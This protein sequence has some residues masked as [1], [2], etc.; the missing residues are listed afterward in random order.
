MSQSGAKKLGSGP[1]ASSTS[2][3]D[4]PI[5]RRVVDAAG[6]SDERLPDIQVN[7]P[8]PDVK[9][10]KKPTAAQKRAARIK[11]EIAKIIEA[12]TFK[13]KLAPEPLIIRPLGRFAERVSGAFAEL[14]ETAE[15][16]PL[17]HFTAMVRTEH[18][19][20][21]PDRVT[22]VAIQRYVKERGRLAVVAAAKV[23]S[24]GNLM[25]ELAG[26]AVVLPKDIEDRKAWAEDTLLPGEAM[27]IVRAAL[28]IGELR[29]YLGESLS[30]LGTE[31]PEDEE[32]QKED[33]PSRPAGQ[34]PAES[35]ELSSDST[36][37]GQ[38][39]STS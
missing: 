22:A 2:K 6:K 7:V 23:A 33:A 39:S 30:I 19:D 1:G 28:E 25:Y 27:R 34:S 3:T 12:G 17:D 38:A 9:P 11:A 26:L 14:M 21:H 29:D 10:P 35:E 37:S 24:E 16:P 32:E 4:G 31:E 13:A 5:L 20:W 15:S 36:T 8:M 18:P